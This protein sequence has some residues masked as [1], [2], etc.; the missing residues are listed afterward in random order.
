MTFSTGKKI[1]A[2]PLLRLPTKAKSDDN[3]S[4]PEEDWSKLV[5]PA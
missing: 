4:L 2:L 5:F 3:F 1:I